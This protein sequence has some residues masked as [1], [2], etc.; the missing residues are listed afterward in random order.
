VHIGVKTDNRP[1][2]Y[3]NPLTFTSKN[4]FCVLSY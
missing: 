2:S 4:P 1:Q 3:A